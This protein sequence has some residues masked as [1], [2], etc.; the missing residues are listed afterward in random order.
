M[1]SNKCLFA[2][3]MALAILAFSC[4]LEQP[5]TGIRNTTQD[6]VYQSIG[7]ALLQANPHDTIVVG[8]GVYAED[9]R[10]SAPITLTGVGSPHIGAVTIDSS[11]VTLQ[12]FAIESEGRG[13]TITHDNSAFSS[14]LIKDNTI[15]SQGHGI[16][17]GNADQMND[18]KAVLTDLSIISNRFIGGEN[19]DYTNQGIVLFTRLDGITHIAGNSFSDKHAG[20]NAGMN[21]TGYC[22][23]GEVFITDNQILGE[24][25]DT[26][27]AFA[28]WALSADVVVQQGN[29]VTVGYLPE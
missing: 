9:L 21:K 8:P 13:I 27:P 14:I 5:V 4:S 12:G 29:E 23:T 11:D 19:S 2:I 24:S 6:I 22:A 26:P 16:F 1:N 10:L 17:R 18:P 20:L 15:D 25:L 3:V 7:A 28:I